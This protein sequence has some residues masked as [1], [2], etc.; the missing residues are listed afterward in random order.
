[1]V[2]AEGIT[3][4]VGDIE[5]KCR[6]GPDDTV[7]ALATIPDMLDIAVELN[8]NITNEINGDRVVTRGHHRP[9]PTPTRSGGKPSWA[10]SLADTGGDIPSPNPWCRYDRCSGS[11]ELSD[12]GTMIE[13]EDI[14]KDQPQ[15]KRCRAMVLS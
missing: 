13:W 1:M 12:D 11:G 8:T 3:E 5:L 4:V 2:R 10:L 6:I 15:F 9:K 7:L 14:P